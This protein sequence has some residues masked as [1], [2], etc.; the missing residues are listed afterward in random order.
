MTAT[1]NNPYSSFD[2]P[3]TVTLIDPA[4]VI[5][6]IDSPIVIPPTSTED[7]DECSDLTTLTIEAP[8]DRIIE[9][10][11]GS[12]ELIID[13]PIFTTTSISCS[14]VSKATL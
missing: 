14:A 11:I 5:I 7:S 1:T 6:P 10:I 9:Y 4:D 13:Y 3:Y 12:G 2:F 8:E